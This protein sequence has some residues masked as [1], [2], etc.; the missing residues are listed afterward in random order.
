MPS[1]TASWSLTLKYAVISAG[2]LF[3][4]SGQPLM[5]VFF[6]ACRVVS[7]A[8]ACWIS[9]SFESDTGRKLAALTFS[10]S[11]PAGCSVVGRYARDSV[12]AKCM[13][14]PRS[15]LTSKVYFCNL[16]IIPCS[17]RGAEARGFFQ[18]GF[19]GLV[20]TLYLHLPYKG[21]MV[22]FFEC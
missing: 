19:E 20:G 4:Y 2:M 10:N 6:S 17:R 13:F 22:E 5:I 8:V 21:I 1:C 15:Y 7:S 11:A 12:S 18:Y 16:I 14:F 3:L 9:L